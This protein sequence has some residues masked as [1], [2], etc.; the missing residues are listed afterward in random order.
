MY[1]KNILMDGKEGI[2][3]DLSNI[4][5]LINLVRAE[6]ERTPTAYWSVLWCPIRIG[7]STKFYAW[8]PC[9]YTMDTEE[10]TYET[11]TV[12]YGKPF[13]RRRNSLLLNIAVYRKDDGIYEAK[14]EKAV[15]VAGTD[16]TGESVTSYT[17]YDTPV[18]DSST[19][20]RDTYLELKQVVMAKKSAFLGFV[21]EDGMIPTISVLATDVLASDYSTT[22]TKTTVKVNK[23][24]R[25]IDNSV[26]IYTISE[27]DVSPTKPTFTNIYKHEDYKHP[28][29]RTATDVLM[30]KIEDD[31]LTFL[32]ASCNKEN[33]LYQEDVCDTEK[34]TITLESTEREVMNVCSWETEDKYDLFYHEGKTEGWVKET[35][36]VATGLQTPANIQVTDYAHHSDYTYFVTTTPY[37]L[38]EHVLYSP[39]VESGYVSEVTDDSLFGT[40]EAPTIKDILDTQVNNYFN[41]AY[42]YFNGVGVA[43]YSK[44]DEMY[45]Y[46]NHHNTIK[47]SSFQPYVFSCTDYAEYIPVFVKDSSNQMRMLC[48]WKLEKTTVSDKSIE[49]CNLYPTT[50]STYYNIKS[51]KNYLTSNNPTDKEYL[52]NNGGFVRCPLLDEETTLNGIFVKGTEQTSITRPN[53]TFTSSTP[54]L[55]SIA[56][57]NKVNTDYFTV[58]NVQYEPTRTA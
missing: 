9:Y 33:T 45:S 16:S 13:F 6:L 50:Y 40:T 7:Q 56:Y 57:A 48:D 31:D 17:V 42:T 28:Y 14:E 37:T 25:I 8:K 2:Y 26:T 52:F 12:T 35:A 34:F 47:E 55:H 49:V 51:T 24:N 3:T 30:N 36:D 43:K 41:Q 58:M 27:P 18:G 39:D 5:E 44:D 15:T 53:C 46:I 54:D 29:M 10:I 21:Y 22:S 38:T 19:H 32:L 20:T 23:I 4:Q 11:R 1:I